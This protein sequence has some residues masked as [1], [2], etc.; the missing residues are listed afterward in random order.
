[1]CNLLSLSTCNNIDWTS[2]WT[3]P[4]TPHQP[5]STPATSHTHHG[6]LTHPPPHT[7]TPATSH[8]IAFSIQIMSNKKNKLDSTTV[9]GKLLFLFFSLRYLNNGQM[10]LH[11]KKQSKKKKSP[12]QSKKKKSSKRGK[13]KKISKQRRPKMRMRKM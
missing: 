2:L 11:Q 7:P 12:K 9:A 8:L 10:L 4:T 3:S 1:M 5:T 13:E 6:H